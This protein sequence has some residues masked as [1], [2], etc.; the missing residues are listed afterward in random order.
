[1]KDG[2]EV[3]TFFKKPLSRQNG[4]K[5]NLY[6]VAQ[7]ATKTDSQKTGGKKPASQLREKV[8][9]LCEGKGPMC[10]RARS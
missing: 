10:V 7:V 5:V 4:Y 3:E 9:D 8:G 2:V 1:M 6:C